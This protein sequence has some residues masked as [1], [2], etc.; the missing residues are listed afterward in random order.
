MI[1]PSIIPVWVKAAAIALALAA[2]GGMLGGGYS[3]Y[4]AQLASRYDAGYAAGVADFEHQYAQ[5]A[6]AARERQIKQA[7]A[8]VAAAAQAGA[9]QEQ[10]RSTLDT[11]YDYLGAQLAVAQA[12]GASHAHTAN[13]PR[14]TVD[15]AD[16]PAERLSIWRAANS[17][18]AHRAA[19][20]AS[21]PASQPAGRTASTPAASGWAHQDAGAQPP[22]SH[23]AVS[24]AGNANLRPAAAPASGVQRLQPLA[25]PDIYAGS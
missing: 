3:A 20:A 8:D 9:E 6:S 7:E 11:H 10:R 21:A 23:S 2:L 13:P 1:K 14:C 16:L 12:K 5:A 18:S 19:A 24:P 17:G 25:Q 15:D 4:N 22:G